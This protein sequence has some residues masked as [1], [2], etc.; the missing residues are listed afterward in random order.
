MGT[1]GKSGT[2][3]R[4]GLSLRTDCADAMM[5]V[6]G[7]G[8]DERWLTVI[9]AVGIGTREFQP[10]LRVPSASGMTGGSQRRGMGMKLEEM[11]EVVFG[12]CGTTATTSEEAHERKTGDGKGVLLPERPLKTV[13]KNGFGKTLRSSWTRQKKL[14][15]AQNG[16]IASL[17]TGKCPFC[18]KTVK[19]LSSH[20][21][22]MHWSPARS[23]TALT[24][25]TRK[26]VSDEVS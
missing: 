19:N 1:M 26:D 2:R 9:S 13:R 20:I 16:K 8:G 15:E 21:S 5:R 23:A 4:R 18:W 6:C 3:L 24:D 22:I 25:S 12:C 7:F 10:R 17:K 14:L 11:E